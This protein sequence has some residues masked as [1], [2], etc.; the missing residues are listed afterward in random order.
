MPF[1][2]ALFER[3][4]FDTRFYAITDNPS[5]ADAVLMP[6]AYATS[7]RS[8]PELIEIC[9]AEAAKLNLPLVVDGS[10]DIDWPIGGKNIFV[11]RHGGYRFSKKPY[12]ISIPFYADDLLEA[13][14]EGKFEPR[15]RSEVPSISFAGW[16]SLTPRQEIR[17]TLKELPDRLCALFDGRFGAKK[18]GIFFRREA[19]D[20]LEKSPLVHAN[21][22][23]RRSYSGHV[24]TAQKSPDE[25]RKEFVTNMLGSGYSLDV[26]GDANNSIRLFE[27]LS[28]GRIPIIVD[29]ERNFPFR[30]KINYSDFSLMVDFKDIKRLPQIVA[31]FNAS[32]S[33]EQFVDMQKKAREAFVQYFR[34]DSMTEPL[35][36]EIRAKISL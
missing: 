7:V 12:D 3:H 23:V 11:L 16:A 9:T 5:E 8:F 29:T 31:E 25:L 6:Y 19:V 26:R 32:L 17:A 27:I 36:E 24:D 21:F 18:K 2:H 28:L 4:S 20:V 1:F 15:Q 30:D 35:M 33:D 10:G 14:C 13:F 34:A 22:L